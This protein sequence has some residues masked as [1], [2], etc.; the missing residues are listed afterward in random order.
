MA[1]RVQSGLPNVK[2]QRNAASI[3]SSGMS[4][5]AM[6]RSFIRCLHEVA[7]FPLEMRVAQT[8]EADDGRELYPSVAPL[9]VG[10]WGIDESGCFH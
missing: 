8:I 2:V 9:V 7:D 1:K 6:I 4:A 10:P 3:S 5:R